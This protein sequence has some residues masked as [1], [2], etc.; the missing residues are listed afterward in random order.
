[1]KFAR[2]SGHG[3]WRSRWAAIGAAV[4]VTLGGGGMFVA[5]AADGVPSSFVAVTPVR[6][7]DSRVGLGLDGP[8]VSTQ[9]VVVQITGSVPTA[10]GPSVVV[11]TGATAVVANVT[12]VHPTAAGFMSVRPVGATGVPSTSSLNFSAGQ[13]VGNSLTMQLPVTGNFQL[14]YYAAGSSGAT[15]DL[16]IDVAGYYVDGGTQGPVGPQ[17][18]AGPQGDAGAT[19]ATVPRSRRSTG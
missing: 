13:I 17:G 18:P 11:P 19:G 12:V 7:V 9:P 2:G 6:M 1:M 8:L 10:A 14:Y 4:A 3:L 16:V 5:S 15:V